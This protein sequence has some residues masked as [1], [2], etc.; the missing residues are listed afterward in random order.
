MYVITYLGFSKSATQ[1][2]NLLKSKEIIACF[3][4]P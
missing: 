3:S 2:Y 1:N 4:I